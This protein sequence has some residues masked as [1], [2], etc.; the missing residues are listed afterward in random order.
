MSNELSWFFNPRSIAVV[1]ASSKP[2]KIGHESLRSLL[3]SGFSGKIYPVN[4]RAEEI[5]GLKA[6][7]SLLDIPDEVD[8]A[9][10]TLPADAVPDVM[11]QCARRGV[12]AVVIISGGFGEA[13]PEG[14]RIEEEVVKIAR[15]NGIRIIGPNC[16][17]VF[18]GHSRVDTSFQPVERMGRPGPGSVAFLSQSGTFG[19]AFLDWAAEDNLGVSKVVSLGNRCDVDEADLI[20]YLAEDPETEVIGVYIESFTRGRALFNSIRKCRK[21]IVIY[22]TSKTGE[23]ARAAVSHTGRIA[24]RHEIAISALKQAGALT[25]DSFNELYAA[26]KA[27]A[28]QPAAEKGV[29]MVTNGAGPCVMA[30]DELV[31][32]GVPLASL[33]SSTRKGLVRILPPYVL[34][35]DFVIDL[36]GSATSKDYTNA[37]EIL[38]KADEVGIIGIFVVFQDSPLEDNFSEVLAGFDT[39]KPIVVFAAGG[40]Y[41]RERRSILEKA[42]IPTYDDVRE[43]ASACLALWWASHCWRPE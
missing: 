41:T 6:Y 28:K 9:V 31:L 22:K 5:L 13:G 8:M 12:K 35:S 11:T 15:E 43:F 21:P 7:P 30:A 40:R 17:G 32:R 18:D 38:S 34:V 3:T 14:G 42:G 2:G 33:S 23:S 16:I 29:V 4:P 26:V 37:I 10:I 39:K 24:A 20:E 36:T 27:L 25:V 1:G 19:A